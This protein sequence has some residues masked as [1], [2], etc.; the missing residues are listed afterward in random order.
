MAGTGGSLR[1]GGTIHDA[2]EQ[3]ASVHWSRVLILQVHTHESGATTAS[4]LPRL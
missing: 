1:D 2:H 3:K 4:D